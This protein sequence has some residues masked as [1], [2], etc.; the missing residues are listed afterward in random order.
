MPN[1][2]AR[3]GRL[4][5]GTDTTHLWQALPPAD[6]EAF[7]EAVLV[8]DAHVSMRVW[9]AVVEEYSQTLGARFTHVRVVRLLGTDETVPT[10]VGTDS[11]LGA[12]PE[13]VRRV[14]LVVTD[15]LAAGWHLGT[16]QPLLRDW[17]LTWPL[18]VINVLPPHLW[19]RTG[20]DVSH[21]QVKA[22]DVWSANIRWQ[23]RQWETPTGLWS[24]DAAGAEEE[25]ESTAEADVPSV[26]PV[27]SLTQHG[28]QA[29]S[30]VFSNTEPHWRDLPALF[31]HRWKA[32]PD[33]ARALPWA[34]EFLAAH[35]PP[36]AATRVSDFRA[37]ASPTAF[38]L[39]TRLAASPLSLPVVRALIASTAGAGPVHASELFLGGLVRP[40][41]VREDAPDAVVY[42]FLPD[43]R[44]QLLA[45]GR[46][47]ATLRTVHEVRALLAAD[48]TRISPLPP[49][50]AS[51]HDPTRPTINSRNAH[52]HRVELSA[53]TALSF[54][55][56][57]A[58]LREALRW[59][60]Q[61]HALRPSDRP[62]AAPVVTPPVR[63]IEDQG[64]MRMTTTPQRPEEGVRTAQPRIWSLPPRNQNFTGRTELLSLLDESLGEG[65]TTVLPEAIHGMGGVGKTQLAIEYAYRHQSEFDI[66]WWIPSERPGQ[67]GQSLVE[68]ARRLGL[69]TTS[70]INVAGPAVRE[71]LREGKPFSKWMLIFDNA[72]SPEQVRPY[73]PTGGTG[74][75]LV[76]S[77]N[78]RWG[79]V[80]GSLEVD[81]FTREESKQLLRG[82][83]PMLMEKEAEALAEALGDLPLALVQAAA[84]RT[85]TGMPASEYLRL[86]ESKKSEL[87]ETAPPPDYQLP[88]AAAWNVSLD[89][90]ETRSLAA[91][92]L[93]QLCSYFAPDPI[94]RKIL[95]R[96]ESN[97]DDPFPELNSTLSDPMKLARAIREI[98]RYSLAR[99]DHR[100]NSIEMH[101][102]VQHVLI[103]R[104]SPQEQ[105]SMR[106]SAHRLMA[107]AD[108]GTPTD[109]TS[110]DRYAELYTHV[111]ASDALRSSQSWTRDLVINVAKYL[112]H[113]GDHE[114]A[115]DFSESAWKTWLQLFGEEDQQT[116]LMGQ[117]LTWMYWTVGRYQEA[118]DLVEHVRR[119]Y[120]RV[121]D[122]DAESTLDAIDTE[123]GVRRAEGRFQDAVELNRVAYE[124][125]V[126]A[127]REDDPVTLNIAHNLG[128]S[129]RLSG[130][131]REAL[132]LD[133]RT[134]ELKL[135]VFG[136][137]E[138]RSL[139]TE[140]SIAID[141][142]EIGDYIGARRL[143]ESALS[144]S[145]E[146]FGSDNPNTIDTVRE[147]GIACR[148]AGD[149]ARALEL[150]LESQEGFTRRYG[151]THPRS[152]A[153]A[154]TLAIA[155]RQNGDLDAAHA[156]GLQV[157]AGYRTVFHT[158]HPYT[159]SADVGLAVSERLLG[160]PEEARR[161]D[162]AAQEA[163]V[164]IVGPL[165]P[166]A[167]VTAINLASDLAALGDH[168]AAADTG[169]DVLA[170]CLETFGPD[171]PTTLACAGN[172][173]QDLVSVGLHDEGAALRRDTGE[174]LDRVLNTAVGEESTALHP[175][176]VEF[177]AGAR[178]NCDID[179]LPL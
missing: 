77:R 29:L 119:V 55:G 137:D 134:W 103:N 100:T 162:E 9:D 145:R 107:T 62:P 121:A 76:T 40:T 81:V 106:E 46:R 172:L 133:R 10:R 31:A 109:P 160:R 161:L 143:Q 15:G 173:A 1:D 108:P 155:L 50:S 141:V 53:M 175:A 36:S 58:L 26:V 66:I 150:A 138:Q 96:R 89:H 93:L 130:A 23:C 128:V 127:F 115:V 124:R 54:L 164:D 65:T 12:V 91:L 126:N 140:N 71:A 85:E 4:R 38:R 64:V 90:L 68:L 132:E 177:R 135:R 11:P 158:R 105:D 123:A 176:S 167:L 154:L 82:S 113:W 35:G 44:E 168:Q 163:L 152:L 99:I 2:D 43:A 131:F 49:A 17:T 120:D 122:S 169:R 142:R 28:A 148:K 159:M 116:L 110:W 34:N 144:A 101:R 32:R 178:A 52:F 21:V 136:R 139:I 57:A 14:I 16:V 157:C 97:R 6:G 33:S 70:E 118:S 45:A 30:V 75:I 88:V 98:N 151:E 39:A 56:R 146:L 94:S 125:A 5:S 8:V 147:L 170:R 69:T 24:P 149:H 179:P 73:F 63:P 48:P 166:F 47:S 84:W 19:F 51:L 27:L 7:S 114:V 95:S 59:H 60:D 87:L 129:L 78:R 117:W 18:A 111:M 104:M 153:S 79:L 92:R 37:A 112:Y 72:D 171:H 67:I 174:R 13:G 80:G 86:F 41:G 102:L 42:D 25:S 22:P 74:T 3:R 165:H 156:R 61:Q 20:L 83:G